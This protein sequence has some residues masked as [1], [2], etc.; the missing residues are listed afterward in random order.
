MTTQDDLWFIP[1]YLVDTPHVRLLT[2]ALER[3]LNRVDRRALE[4]GLVG[5]CAD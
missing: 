5:Y 3:S 2:P 4:A 1:D